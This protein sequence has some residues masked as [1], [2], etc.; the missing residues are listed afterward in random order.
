MLTC[1]R[2]DLRFSWHLQF[3]WDA[4]NPKQS[5]FL[6]MLIVNYKPSPVMVVLWH[7]LAYTILRLKQTLMTYASSESVT[8]HVP[9]LDE[10]FPLSERNCPGSGDF[11]KICSFCGSSLMPIIEVRDCEY[12][13]YLKTGYWKVSI[14]F[15]GYLKT[16]ILHFSLY[17]CTYPVNRITFCRVDALAYS[18]QLYKNWLLVSTA[19]KKQMSHHTK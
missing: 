12:P 2:L 6:W 4:P 3:I 5:Q 19:W 9:N 10:I 17:T 13:G 7:W 8:Q 15:H 16:V 11:P 14:I 18:S 1:P